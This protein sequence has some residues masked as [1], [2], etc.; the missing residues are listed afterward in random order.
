[1]NISRQEEKERLGLAILRERESIARNESHTAVKY[2][3]RIVN[4][5]CNEWF[6]RYDGD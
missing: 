2:F 1:M 6:Y 3:K 5:L 4:I